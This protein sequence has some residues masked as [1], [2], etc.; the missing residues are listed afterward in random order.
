MPT[1]APTSEEQKLNES[2]GGSIGIMLNTGQTGGRNIYGPN[3]QRLQAVKAK[4]DPKNLFNVN[5]NIVPS[6]PLDA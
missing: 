2:E 1:E 4:Y 6:Q 5:D 3:L